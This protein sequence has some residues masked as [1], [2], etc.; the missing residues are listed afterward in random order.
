MNDFLNISVTTRDI[1]TIFQIYLS[2]LAIYQRFFKYIYH[3][4]RYINDLTQN[5]DLPA[6]NDKTKREAV[7]KTTSL[8]LYQLKFKL[9]S[10]FKA[11]F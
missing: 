2:Q 7:Q 6:K 1:S 3:N 8:F 5:I 10:N 11:I 4:S 9:L